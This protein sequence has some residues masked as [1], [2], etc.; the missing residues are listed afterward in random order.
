MPKCIISFVDMPDGSVKTDFYPDEPTLKKLLYKPH[1][2]TMAHAL[3]IHALEATRKRIKQATE[4]P[5]SI[6]IVKPGQSGLF[7]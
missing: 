1:E 4:D 3:L 2:M 7:Q 6:Q 5:N